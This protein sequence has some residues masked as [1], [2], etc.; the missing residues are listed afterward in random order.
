M[1]ENAV[2]EDAAVSLTDEQ[3]AALELD[4]NVAITAG[5]GTGKTTVL[6]KRYRK[7]LRETD[8]TPTEIVAITFTNDAAN[9][10]RERIRAAVDDELSAASGDPDAYREWRE[11]KDDLAD[12]YVHTIHGFCAR[13]LR[14]HAVAAP[15]TPEFEVYDETDATV[16]GREVVREVVGDR[17]ADSDDD[18]TRLARLWNRDTLEDVLAGLLAQR[19]ESEAWV[20]RWR[21][22]TP[23]DYHDFLWTRVHPISP[24]V[25]EDT[26]ADEGVREA[27]RT[28]RRL[29]ESGVLSMVA[30]EDDR[31]AAKIDAVSSLLDEYDPLA[32][33]GSTRARQQFLDALCD[34]LTTNDGTRRGHDWWYWGSRSRWSDADLADEQ[35]ALEG[36]IE[37]LFDG[38]DPESLEFG[39]ERDEVAARY[40]LALARVFDDVLDAYADAKASRNVLDYDDLVETTIEFLEDSPGVRDQLREEFE[41]VMVDEV[42]DTDPRQWDL[43]QLLTDRDPNGGA[44]AG[45]NVFLV[46][47]EKQSIYRFRGADVTSFADARGDLAA[48][49]PDGVETSLELTGNF[50]TTDET[51]DFCNDVFDRVFEPFGDGDGASDPYEPFEARPQRLTA[52]RP[53]GREVRGTAEYLVVPDD[54]VEPLHGPG[55]LDGAPHFSQPG[56]RE[57]HALAARLT[58]LFADPPTVYDEEGS[59]DENGNGD[60]DAGGGEYRDARPEDVAVL[61]RSRTRLKAYE[62]AF[63]AQDVPY[64]VVSGT[65]F[66]DSPEVTAV[67]NLLRVLAD[68][69]NERALY[70]VLRSPLFGVPDDDVA[71][72]RLESGDDGLWGALGA[73]A[74]RAGEGEGRGDEATAVLADAYASVQ[75]WRRRAGTHPEV[76]PESA[77]PWGTLL[78]EVIDETGYLASIA[79]DERP[80]QAAVNVNQLREQ[81]R[82]WEE[83][84]VK[85]PAEIV[86]RLETRR[87]VEAHA[88]EATIPEDAEG[89]QLRTVHSA[90][91]L[92]FEVVVVPELGTEFNFQADVDAFGRVYFE[93]FDLDGDGSGAGDRGRTPVLGI[94]APSRDDPFTTDDTLVRRVTRDRMQAQERAELERLLYVA[95][96]RTRDHLLLSGLHDVEATED[97]R[98]EL[99]DANDGSEANCWRDWLQPVLLEGDGSVVERLREADAVEASLSN[100][101]YRVSRPSAPVSDWREEGETEARSFGVDIPPVETT[102]PPRVITASNY[103]DLV[104]D[105]GTGHFG[106]EGD[107]DEEVGDDTEEVEGYGTGLRATTLGDIV[108]R[109]C[110]RR[111]PRDRWDG[112]ARDVARQEGESVTDGDLDRVLTYADR[113]VEFVDQYE[114]SRSVTATF[115]ELSVV[116]RFDDA[117]IVG[118][119]DHL[120][121]TPD[122]YH[123]IDYKTNS[124]AGR[125]LED[126]VDY[127]RPQ[128]R[129]Y[130]VAL[131]QSDPGRAVRSVLY[132]T[133]GDQARVEEFSPEEL[134]VL[135]SDVVGEL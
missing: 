42:Q 75:R 24:D 3:A 72:L 45:D 65:G 25:A 47:D 32:P 84:G 68:P 99:A 115:D 26:L 133:D 83:A 114:A 59:G 14:E 43:V 11:V 40:V 28:I 58:Q 129:A 76:S 103:A 55:Y 87:D 102:S 127:Y 8:A 89:V 107:A 85:T 78:S 18:V 62:R 88:A 60:D 134:G 97:G 90:K 105:E 2:D 41:Y 37:T 38:V 6:T 122:A 121:V 128:L 12:G 52:K 124:L 7:I 64:T 86:D 61:L 1:T 44:Y 17:L 21:D 5:A 50:R 111:P 104:A 35:A 98:V 126:L 48:A 119:V 131:Y 46:G 33:D 91:G 13:L 31:G 34:L 81:L 113:A 112:Y 100:S 92:E 63:D 70:G 19:P 109:I 120:V 73:V 74:A 116:V 27:L 101:E 117:R 10:L 67:V 94:K 135:E 110:E 130:A 51:L 22:A 54:D 15:V 80:R 39:V 96:T 95:M 118:D 4:H 79:G 93:T 125:D 9:E 106:P 69:G 30:P 53:A 29:R 132:F 66:Y 49:N 57:A 77:T 108:H 56:D 71:R 16:L 20:D 23:A 123:V 36:A 82:T